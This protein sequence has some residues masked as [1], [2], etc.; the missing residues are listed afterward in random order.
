MSQTITQQHVHTEA[1]GPIAIPDLAALDEIVKP[2]PRELDLAARR[3]FELLDTALDELK[4]K[5]AEV[6]DLREQLR[7]HLGPGRFLISGVPVLDILRNRRW[8]E[9]RARLILPRVLAPEVLAELEVT[10]I[11]RK[12]AQKRVPA[13]YPFCQAGAGKHIVRRIETR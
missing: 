8:S 10:V 1:D 4:A 5:E 12:R 9:E 3:T 11:D 2:A 7:S 13:M 6:E